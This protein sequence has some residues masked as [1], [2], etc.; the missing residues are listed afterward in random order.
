MNDSCFQ[1]NS[2]SDFS[3]H[4]F[5]DVDVNK[6]NINEKKT[7]FINR[8]L[9]YGLLKDWKLLIKHYGLKEIARIAMKI[10]NLDLKT[11]SLIANLANVSKEKFLCYTTK[12]LTPEHW[13][14]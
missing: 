6:V 11:A 1:N 9:E 4:L 13:N 3:P 7:W 8:V 5:W 10:K 14:F 12:S 2:L